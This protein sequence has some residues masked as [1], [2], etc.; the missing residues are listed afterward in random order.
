MSEKLES[1]EPLLPPDT[2]KWPVA[3]VVEIRLMGVFPASLYLRLQEEMDRAET[4]IRETFSDLGG[5][6]AIRQWVEVRP[7]TREEILYFQ[8]RKRHFGPLESGK[9]WA[10][11]TPHVARRNL[12]RDRE[13]VTCK[14]CKRVLGIQE[15]G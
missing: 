1:E 6:D 15:G 10:C 11:D 4:S 13:Q 7:A 2:A 9:R 5:R 8:P 14:L 12:T 3:T